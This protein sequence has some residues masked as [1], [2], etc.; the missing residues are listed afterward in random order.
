MLKVGDRVKPTAQCRKVWPGNDYGEGIG[1]VEEVVFQ[2][3]PMVRW[4]GA[5]IR[6]YYKPELL[7]LHI[8]QLEND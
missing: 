2:K 8:D 7:E 6:C 1:T 5:P 3:Y 4:G